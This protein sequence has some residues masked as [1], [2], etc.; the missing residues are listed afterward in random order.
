MNFVRRQLSDFFHLAT[1]GRRRAFER[2]RRIHDLSERKRL[3]DAAAARLPHADDLIDAGG[4]EGAAVGKELAERGRADLPDL[5]TADQIDDIRQHIADLLAHDP[6]RPEL[7]TYRAPHE[8]PPQTHV[9]HYSNEDIVRVPHL[10]K[11][12][13]HPR[14]LAPVARWL[15]G[16][17]T[18]AALRLWWSTPS[19]D[20]VPEHAELFHRDVDDLRFVKLFVYLTDVTAE[21]GPHVFVDGSHVV[22]RMTQIRRYEDEEV[23]AAFGAEK[24]VQLEGT[25]GTAFLENTYGMHRGVPP[26]TGPRLIFQPLYALRPLVYGPRTPPIRA[27]EAPQG[28]DPY[29]NRVFV[30]GQ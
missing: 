8:V 23:A 16:R 27:A 13:N 5:V 7:G 4:S 24:I 19:G 21:T 11:L 17:P 3:A 26:I 25:A 2:Q 10:L 9:S 14:V 20:G 28:L 18:I 12:A 30:Q 1:D 22:D 6:Y 15:G 29:V